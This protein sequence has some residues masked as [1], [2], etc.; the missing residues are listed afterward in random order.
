VLFA[1]SAVWLFSES[2]GR[3]RRAFGWI[4][5]FL[6]IAGGIISAPLALPILK[7]ETLLAYQ[8]RLGVKS[9]PT[10][11]SFKGEM[12]QL[13]ADQFGWEEMVQRVAR[14]Y[15]SLPPD[16]RRKTAIYT[17]NYG[18]AGAIDFYGPKYGLPPAISGHQNY[19]LWGPRD[20]TG[21]SIILVGDSPDPKMWQ[22]LEVIDHTN[23]PYAMWF[24]N[25]PIYH[26]RGL[27][28]PLSK[29]WPE[30]KHWR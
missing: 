5:V 7:P 27:K 14:Y 17:G 11:V 22:S 13:F 29:V 8:R 1:A 18:E 9:Q 26:G 6:V 19:F 15:N 25:Q 12:P 23:H 30:V 28:E 21:E 16:L 20:S 2:A 4:A 24:E 3:A 10:E